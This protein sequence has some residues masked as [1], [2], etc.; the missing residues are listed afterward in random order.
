[1]RFKDRYKKKK[2]F[3]LPTIDLSIIAVMFIL[4]FMAW[5]VAKLE[6]S[7]VPVNKIIPVFT[8]SKELIVMPIVEPKEKKDAVKIGEFVSL[9]RSP[10]KPLAKTSVISNENDRI[11]KTLVLSEKLPSSLNIRVPRILYYSM[12]D[13]PVKAI[14]ESH[15]GSIIIKVYVLKNGRVGNAVLMQLSGQD[16]LD[17]ASISAVSQWV[18]EPAVLGRQPVEFYFNIPI[19]FRLN[20]N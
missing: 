14:E 2:S 9:G 17:K 13:Y 4:V 6:R 10:K 1:M 19:R 18:F 7:F 11:L 15:E 8:I 12:P 5:G 16:I 3:H 20:P